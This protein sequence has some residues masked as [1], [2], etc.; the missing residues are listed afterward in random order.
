MAA[1]LYQQESYRIVGLCMEVHRELGRGLSEVVYKDALEQEF[2]LSGVHFEREMPFTVRY[3][4][5]ELA[6]HYIADFVVEKAIL[7]EAKA[8]AGLDEA[9]RKQ[10]L[11]YLGISKLRLGLLVNFG[12]ESLDHQRIIL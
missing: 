11:N 10:V 6:H 8:C 2:R 9:H 7:L 5:R 3:K 4:G 1:L 12:G